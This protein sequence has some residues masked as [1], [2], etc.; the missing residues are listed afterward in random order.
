MSRARHFGAGYSHFGE[1]TYGMDV[2]MF[3]DTTGKYALWDASDNKFTISGTMQFG[4]VAMAALALGLGASATPLTTAVADKNFFASYTQSTATSGDSR[5]AY[6]KHTLGGTIAATGYGDGV[7]AFTVVTGTGY[8]YASGLHATMSIS[9][10]ASVTG[11]GAGLRATLGAA[12]ATRTLAGALSAIHVCSDVGA[13]NTMPTV[14]G[15]MR[16]TDDGTVRMSNLA[17]IPVAA[18]GTLLAAHDTQAMTHSIRIIDAAGVA[19]YIMCTNA[20]TNRS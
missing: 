3:G 4:T 9:A 14:H 13:N 1:D 18:N 20:A 17:V 5:G 8:S 10:G 19:Y 6:I 12:A 15:F 2:K 7:R 16:F 11:S